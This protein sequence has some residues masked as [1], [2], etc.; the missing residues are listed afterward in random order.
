MSWRVSGRHRHRI[1]EQIDQWFWLWLTLT[2]VFVF[3]SSLNSSTP[4]LSAHTV[5]IWRST[6]VGSTRISYNPFCC[7]LY[8][9]DCCLSM[10]CV[11]LYCLCVHSIVVGFVLQSFVSCV[12]YSILVYYILLFL[13]FVLSWHSARLSRRWILSFGMTSFLGFVPSLGISHVLFMA[14]VR[15]L[16]LIGSESAAQLSRFLAGT[17]CKFIIIILPPPPRVTYNP[18]GVRF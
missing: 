12:L 4:L 8:C 15:P 10:Y 5:I 18:W 16:S 14:F 7:I 9:I 17:L 2:L 13:M 11:A 3:V 1:V 6:K